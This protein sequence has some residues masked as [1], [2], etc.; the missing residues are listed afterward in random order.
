ME[1]TL[2]DPALRHP[3]S[4]SSPLTA[5][6]VQRERDSSETLETGA[7]SSAHLIAGF[8]DALE[9]QETNRVTLIDTP[10]AS[11]EV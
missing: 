7:Q 6:R 11:F 5:D 3:G 1:S 2:C 8:R 9:M 4:P 10:P